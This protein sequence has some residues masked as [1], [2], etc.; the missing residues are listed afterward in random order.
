MCCDVRQFFCVFSFVRL[1]VFTCLYVLACLFD[2]KRVCL[3]NSICVHLF[4]YMRLFVWSV[5]VCICVRM[6]LEPFLCKRACF[7]PCLRKRVC[8]RVCIVL[9]GPF[10]GKAA[11]KTPLNRR[12]QTKEQRCQKISRREGPF[13]CNRFLILEDVCQEV[14][15][16]LVTISPSVSLGF[17]RQLPLAICYLLI[18][19]VCDI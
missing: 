16:L 17:L 4:V 2:C 15:C 8:L 12:H 18:V 1:Y 7:R 5:W 9:P 6:C 13:C 19:C 14:L 10:D 11:M 3:Y